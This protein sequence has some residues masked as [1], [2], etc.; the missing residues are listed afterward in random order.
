MPQ[1]VEHKVEMARIARKR[2]AAGKPVWDRK[3]NLSGVFHNTDMSFEERR[4][5]IV[6]ILRAST[7]IKGLDEFDNAMEALDGLADAEDTEE[8]DGWFDELYDCAD[9]DRVWITTR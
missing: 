5:A 2:I 9:A 8:F 7:W 3:I 6:R 1:T 4:D